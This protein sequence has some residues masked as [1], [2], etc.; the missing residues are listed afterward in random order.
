[1]KY[2]YL[3]EEKDTMGDNPP[4]YYLWSISQVLKEINRDRSDSW[5]PYN[6]KDWKEGW[7]E[8]VEKDDFCGLRMIGKKR[9]G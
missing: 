4:R 3:V 6:R 7:R 9:I 2:K 5:T 8:F 1:M